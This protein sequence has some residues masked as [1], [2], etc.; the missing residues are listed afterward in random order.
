MKD[1]KLLSAQ[2][3]GDLDVDMQLDELDVAGENNGLKPTESAIKKAIEPMKE[4]ILGR[5]HPLIEYMSDINTKF[6]LLR[7]PT[8][9][10]FIHGLKSSQWA[11]SN[12]IWEKIRDIILSEKE[13]SSLIAFVSIAGSDAI[14]GAFR[15]LLD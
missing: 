4:I 11:V 9:E 2:N 12:K 15:I 5:K 7:S 13:N 3:E 8:E 1:K 6:I 14:Q 10:Y